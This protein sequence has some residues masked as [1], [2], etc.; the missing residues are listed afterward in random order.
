MIEHDRPR[1]RLDRCV[2]VCVCVFVCVRVCV[3]VCMCVCA[4][5]CVRVCLCVCVC[6]QHMR[7]KFE[8]ID[9]TPVF[10]LLNSIDVIGLVDVSPGQLFEW[11]SEWSVECDIMWEYLPR[12]MDAFS[13]KL[14]WGAS[15][16][17]LVQLLQMQRRMNTSC[18]PLGP[19]SIGKGH[20]MKVNIASN[21]IIQLDD[22]FAAEVVVS[23]DGVQSGA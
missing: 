9:S 17:E 1:S 7:R 14:T 2:C 16:E 6:V 10:R 12:P 4:R 21:S 18:V 8:N 22:D 23:K 5:V 3:C 15:V 19:N 20:L 11:N 13:L